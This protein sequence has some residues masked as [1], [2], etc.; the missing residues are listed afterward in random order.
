MPRL[1]H[2]VTL[3]KAGLTL[4]VK[5]EKRAIR[6]HTAAF[7]ALRRATRA[8]TRAGKARDTA[9][10]KRLEHERYLARLTSTPA[11]PTTGKDRAPV[12]GPTNADR[13]DRAEAALVAY[14]DASRCD[15]SSDTLTDL[16]TDLHHYRSREGSEDPGAGLDQ[17][18]ATAHAHFKAEKD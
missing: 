16:F 17:R 4:A 3:A 10:G 13:A 2:T 8:F 12:L 11:S 6:E 14:C 18:L 1:H 15:M 5:E 9:L 7:V